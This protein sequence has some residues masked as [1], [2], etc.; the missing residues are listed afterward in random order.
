MGI[1]RVVGRVFGYV[2][3]WGLSLVKRNGM[4]KGYLEGVSEV[5]VKFV[6]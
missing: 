6:V 3:N 5:G 4:S 2:N 1:G